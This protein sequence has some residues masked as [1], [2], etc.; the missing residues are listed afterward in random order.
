[1]L[2]ITASSTSKTLVLKYILYIYIYIDTV[3]VKDSKLILF[4]KKKNLKYVFFNKNML[5]YTK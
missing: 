2:C 4:I 3:K 5:G 1:M